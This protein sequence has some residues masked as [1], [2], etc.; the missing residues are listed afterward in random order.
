M[1]EHKTIDE[2]APDRSLAGDGPTRSGMAEAR[3][4]AA[5]RGDKHT[6]RK[7]HTPWGPMPG[8]RPRTRLTPERARRYEDELRGR[9]GL[10]PLGVVVPRRLRIQGWIATV[11]TGLI[12]FVTRFWN[13]NHPHALVF[14]ETYY[15]KEAFSL[16]KQGFEGSWTG[17]GS[18]VN[19]MFVNGDYSA[20]SATNAEY[21]VHPPFGKWLMAIGQALFGT[22]NGAGWRFTTAA[23]GVLAVMLITRIALRMFRSPWIAGFAGLAM[24]LD[25]MG[26]VLSRTGIL[27]NILAFLV[28]A[29][30]WAVLRDRDASR[31]KLAHRVAYGDFTLTGKPH[32]PWGPSTRFR[33]WLLLAGVLLGLSC[34]V[35]WSG[36]YAVAVFG[37][38][39][40]VWGITAR[41]AVGTRLWSGAGVFREGF[42][43]FFALVPI[44]LLAYLGAWTSWFLNPNS[45]DRDWVANELNS[46]TESKALSWAP[47]IINNFIHYH[48]R[49]WDFHHGLDS[50]HTYQSQA[51][52]WLF[53]GRPVSFYWEGTDSELTSCDSSGGCVQA[54]T[55][56]GNPAV[57]WLALIGLLVVIWVLIRRRD[58][59][60]GAILAGYLATW[61]PWLTYVNRTIYQFYAVA[62][63]PY[64]VLALAF[65]LAYLVGALVPA[66]SPAVGLPRAPV[67][68]DADDD[69]EE[70][71][72]DG[73]EARGANG[74]GDTRASAGT[75]DA[76]AGTVDTADR[77]VDATAG[78]VDGATDSDTTGAEASGAEGSGAA[79]SGAEG[80]GAEDSGATASGR[81]TS[82]AAASGR[83]TSSAAAASTPFASAAYGLARSSATDGNTYSVEQE[84][85]SSATDSALPSDAYLGVGEGPGGVPSGTDTKT[86]AATPLDHAR[87]TQPD[88]GAG[89]VDPVPGPAPFGPYSP[90]PTPGAPG[91]T[92]AQ[93]FMVQLDADVP[94]PPPEKPRD[95]WLPRR[96]TRSAK[97]AFGVVLGVITVFA[98]FWWPI[99]TGQTVPYTF[100]HIHMW[101]PSWV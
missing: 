13:L 28:L 91:L 97:V 37:L 50:A 35:K 47:D 5:R 17:E 51:W 100:W 6:G 75:V 82:G 40:L 89:A 19:E 48:Q 71:G 94:P 23:L 81:E 62:V 24:A 44:A 84:D 34:G 56:V 15:V 59:R 21:V 9:L 1:T 87:S 73:S 64:V 74:T 10:L 78:A 92:P 53:Q 98:A 90:S 76:S 58:W 27:D 18:I 42:P 85:A 69:A 14:D 57:W 54:I 43:A 29:G 46:A 63:L 45:F 36:I 67:G 26:I 38:L 66:H 11:L 32:D 70:G 52:R 25:G 65:G 8:T 49:M 83:E 86:G 68:D 79:A 30:F 99:W 39:V 33:P 7:L 80:S 96:A 20:L 12:A 22:D 72:E 77:A 93:Q 61:A 101:L 95:W 16:Y 55:S 41:R 60:A 4:D 31:A 3:P 2:N 88:F